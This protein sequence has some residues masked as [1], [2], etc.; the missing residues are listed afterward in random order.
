VR[1]HTNE[2]RRIIN[3][4]GG[5]TAFGASRV[6][7]GC[8]AAATAISTAPVEIDAL[9]DIASDVI[10]AAFGTEAGFV[11]NC[12]A[13]GLVIASGA[14]MTGNDPER[15]KCLPDVSGLRHEIVLQRCHNTDFGAPVGQMVRMTGATLRETGWS[16]SCAPAA[17]ANAIGPLTAA[18]LFV[19]SYETC[20]GAELTL[21]TFAK[22]CHDAGVPVIVDAA[23]E[24]DLR[25]YLATGA[26]LVI[27]SAHKQFGSMTSAMI[28]GRTELVAACRA[29]MGGVGRP[30]KAGKEAIAAAIAS[31]EHVDA[32]YPTHREASDRAHRDALLTVLS[33]LP[34]LTATPFSYAVPGERHNIRIELNKPKGGCAMRDFA[35]RLLNGTPAVAVRREGLDL[36]YLVINPREIPEAEFQPL[37]V[38]LA[39]ASAGLVC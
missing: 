12:S 5:W 19:V 10:A 4:T 1:N 6:A 35:N 38:A 15:A 29:Q 11:V 27:A 21:G 32:L 31:F 37:C 26:D 16:N 24:Y 20:P 13:A 39:A 9:Q 30:G 7:E 2:L 14:V 36:G 18:G 34:A 22:I 28:A 17:V 23:G 25:H 33:A 3:G 8:M